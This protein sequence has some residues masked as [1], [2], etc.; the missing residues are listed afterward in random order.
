MSRRH[1]DALPTPAWRSLTLL[2]CL[3]IRRT[4]L[5]VD[6]LSMCPPARRENKRGGKD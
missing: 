3:G 4:G 1:S 2:G 5:W 6:P